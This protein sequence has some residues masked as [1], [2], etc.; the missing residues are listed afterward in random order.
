MKQRE[1]HT[2]K[3]TPISV[4]FNSMLSTTPTFEVTAKF[5]LFNLMSGNAAR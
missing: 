2:T 3:V 4:H 1:Y 5:A